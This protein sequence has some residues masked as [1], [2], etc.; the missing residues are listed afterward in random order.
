M[1]DMDDYESRQYKQA[2]YDVLHHGPAS[3]ILAVAQ[4]AS[5][6]TV[7]MDIIKTGLL[8][9]EITTEQDTSVVDILGQELDDAS[10]ARSSSIAIA[11]NST[12]T[13]SNAAVGIA[14][15]HSSSQH[16][17]PASL[18]TSDEHRS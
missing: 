14:D 7:H 6:S 17:L 8:L 18:P 11:S 1:N 12:V 2:I 16:A 4:S 3:L 9:R 5:V 15:M 10:I 13:S